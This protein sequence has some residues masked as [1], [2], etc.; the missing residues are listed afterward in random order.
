M[1]PSRTFRPTM[2]VVEDNR[3]D[4]DLLKELFEMC[5][6]DC[7]VHFATD[8]IDASDFLHRRSPH[9]NAPTPNLILMDLNLPRRSGRELIAEI[10]Q[11]AV[12]RPIPV[13][14]LSTSNSQRDVIELYRLGANGFVAKPVDLSQFVEVIRGIAL[15]WLQVAEIPHDL[16]IDTGASRGVYTPPL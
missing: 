12:L 1:H 16:S 15:F 4:S 9:L 14:V 2:L 3:A 10:R 5:N 8:G 7:D 13:L 6:L 11:D